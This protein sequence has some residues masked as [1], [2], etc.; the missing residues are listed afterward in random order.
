M[1]PEYADGRGCQS[2]QKIICSSSR[3]FV[4]AVL[5]VLCRNMSACKPDR[6]VVRL[7]DDINL[8][9]AA[10]TEIVSVSAIMRSSAFIASPTSRRNAD[11][12]MGRRKPRLYYRP[13]LLKDNVCL[14]PESVFLDVN[15]YKLHDFSFADDTY[16]IS[17]IP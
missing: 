1:I 2:L 13:L 8:S 6:L 15:E 9:V 12:R 7:P 16:L 11:R 14:I 4:P 3:S 17:D 10:F 5:T